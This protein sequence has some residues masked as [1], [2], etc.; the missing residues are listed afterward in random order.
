LIVPPDRRHE[1]DEI[2]ER[3]RR[4]EQVRQLETV[5]VRKD[6]SLVNISV[7]VSP[8]FDDDGRV[9]GASTIDRDITF[10]K[11]AEEA[12]RAS[13][14]RYREKARALAE[15]DRRKDEFLA[16][17][18]H[19]LRNPLAP[20]R[21]AV[22]MLHEHGAELEPAKATRA[23]ELISRQLAQLTRLVDDLLDVARITRGQIRLESRPVRLAA[24]IERAIETVRPLFE[25]RGHRFRLALPE[26]DVWIEADPDRL[27]QAVGNLLHNAAKFTPEGGEVSVEVERDGGRVVIQVRDSGPGFPDELVPQVFEL[28]TQGAQSLDR[29]QGGLGLGLALVRRLVE[30]QGGTVAARNRPGGGAELSIELPVRAAPD[31]APASAAPASGPTRPRRILVVDDNLDSA[32]ALSAL[33]GLRGHTVVAV[34]SGPSALE[35]AEELRPEAAILDIGLPEMDGFEVARRLRERFGPDLVLV[36]LTGYGREQDRARGL[37][38]GFDHYLLK[39]VS[40]EALERLL[41]GEDPVGEEPGEA[42]A[43]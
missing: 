39:P 41:A 17:L 38:A 40:S 19:E 1:P 31:R 26:E 10:R 25:A 42:A 18:G 29:S 4:G 43:E 34:A 13:E 20:I 3:I 28:F 37:E 8:I 2:I 15:A 9:I 30:M 24:V 11:Q 22:E 23:V 32:D 36:A 16:M 7:T 12:L 14:E 5:R 35:A 33:L 27:A 21:N 6:G